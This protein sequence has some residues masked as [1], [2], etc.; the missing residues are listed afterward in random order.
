MGQVQALAAA[1]AA[2]ARVRTLKF[3]YDARTLA[4]ASAQNSVAG[5]V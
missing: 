4:S 2:A 3:G 5:R 1:A